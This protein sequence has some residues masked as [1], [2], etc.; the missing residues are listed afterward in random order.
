MIGQG[1]LLE[2]LRDPDLQGAVTL[3]RTPTGISNPK[4][5]E[6]V[7]KDLSSYKRL[8]ANLVQFDACLFC[9]GVTSNGM[10]EET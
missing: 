4:L 10:N 7:H 2:C 9:L 3:G 5:S 8:D 1:A 6:I